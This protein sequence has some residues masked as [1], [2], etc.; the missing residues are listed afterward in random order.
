VNVVSDAGALLVAR[1]G[2]PAAPT[3]L[4]VFDKPQRDALVML[5]LRLASPSNRC[6]RDPLGAV[7]LPHGGPDVQ[8]RASCHGFIGVWLIINGVAY[9]VLSLTTAEV[10][11][12][13]RL[14]LC[15][16]RL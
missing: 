11:G 8:I 12:L 1:A 4:S 9:V 15:A 3:F 16:R 10:Q 14:A 13:L 2:A 6:R 7:A 5:F